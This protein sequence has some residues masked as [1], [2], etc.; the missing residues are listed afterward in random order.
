M[1]RVGE[2]NYKYTVHVYGPCYLFITFLLVAAL[3]SLLRI[4]T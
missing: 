4:L 2:V 1:I 3:E